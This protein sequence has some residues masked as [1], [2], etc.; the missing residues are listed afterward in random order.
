MHLDKRNKTIILLRVSTCPKPS[1]VARVQ[2]SG[3]LGPHLG[4]FIFGPSERNKMT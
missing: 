3:S 4:L 1:K 2:R